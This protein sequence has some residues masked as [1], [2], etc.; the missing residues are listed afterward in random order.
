MSKLCPNCKS[1][2]SN[3]A[4]FC[5][6]CGKNLNSS[7]QATQRVNNPRSGGS[8]SNRW[9][10]Q[11]NRNKTALGVAGVCCFGLIIIIAIFAMSPDHNT[12][13]VN[14]N[15][16]STTPST[17]TTTTPST[18][19]NSNQQP[20]SLSGTGSQTT[21][22]FHWN[23]G[24]ARFNLTYSGEDNF[25]VDVLDSN[26]NIAQPGIA[27]AIGSYN[28]SRVVNLPSGDYMLDVTANG[29]WTITVSSG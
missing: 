10:N 28:G 2:N 5:Q 16:T 19:T 18:T 27:N 23:G 8:I 25:I 3:D 6:N 4:T 15:T 14:T 22:K 9:N 1:G 26:G 20:I 24:A 13:T 11:S 29:Q 21:E 17:T 12:D 7:T